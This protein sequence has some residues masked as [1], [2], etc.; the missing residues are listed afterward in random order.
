MYFPRAASPDD[1]CARDGE[2]VSRKA[3]TRSRA[4]RIPSTRDNH[5][6]RLLVPAG[7]LTA[8]LVE[9]GLHDERVLSGVV[10]IPT[11]PADDAEPERLVERER[12]H[13]AGPD[14]QDDEPEGP[15]AP[16][17]EHATEQRAADPAPTDVG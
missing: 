7:R 10:V 13:V 11:T 16:I 9:T 6:A 8:R 3:I 14:L 1:D 2:G 5:S 15:P 17:V 4:R 12:F